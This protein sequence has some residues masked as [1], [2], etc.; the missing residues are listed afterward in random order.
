[1]LN[2][3]LIWLAEVAIQIIIVFVGGA[4]FQVTRVGGREWGISI[5]LGFVSIPLGALLR[6]IPNEPVE[7]VLQ[8]LR[9]LPKQDVLPT[10]SPEAQW[11]E[12]I[13]LVRDNLTTFANVRGGRLRSSSFAM[14]SR[15]SRVEDEQRPGM[16]VLWS[17]V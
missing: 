12:A 9:I 16:Y 7:M 11:N 5:A 13:Q 14:K 15:K 3:D 10:Q 1:L 2:I 17:G 8:K 6:L 4:A